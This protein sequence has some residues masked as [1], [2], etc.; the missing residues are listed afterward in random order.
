METAHD[1]AK[2]MA[3]YSRRVINYLP[4]IIK[5]YRD[6]DV[7]G[8]SQD[9]IDLIEGIGWIVNVSEVFE[10]NLEIDV[11]AFQ[12][13]LLEMESAMKNQD[14]NHL[15]DVLHYEFT[16]LI[17]DILFKSEEFVSNSLN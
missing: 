15:A 3:E 16:P 9:M 14:N 4:S 10:E 5:Q 6:N 11:D 1:I 12:N 17:E 2:S 7:E 8:A 13:A